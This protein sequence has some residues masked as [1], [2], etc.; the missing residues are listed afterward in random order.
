[1]ATEVA[2][3]RTTRTPVPAAVPVRRPELVVV[4]LVT[5]GFALV[6]LL[7]AVLV[8]AFQAPDERAHFDAALHVAIGD[9]WPEPG[10][11]HVLA[12]I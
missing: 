10:D 3:P 1:M 7:W 9:G 2:P 6:L 8:P 5:A 4:S 11:L 12:A